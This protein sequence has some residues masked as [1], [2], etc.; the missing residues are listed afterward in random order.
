MKKI[1]LALITLMF[2]ACVPS[3]G[4]TFKQEGTKIIAVSNRTSTKSEPV[5]T[6]F[7]YQDNKG[8][9]YPIYMSSTGSCFVNKVSSKTGKEYKYYL[10][11]E[12]SATICKQL[13]V[14]YKPKPKTNNGK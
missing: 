3:Y 2:C 8:N 11:P 13:G 1:I 10:K 9:T 6:K 14:E 7:T 5:K 4:Q 12:I